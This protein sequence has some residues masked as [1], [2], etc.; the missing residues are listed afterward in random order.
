MQVF[1]TPCRGGVSVPTVLD[2]S[3]LRRIILGAFAVLTKRE[4]SEAKTAEK[5]TL[6]DGLVRALSLDNSTSQ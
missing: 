5:A 1:K 2:A 3:Q 6:R 4:T